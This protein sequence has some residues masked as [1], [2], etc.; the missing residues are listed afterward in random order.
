MT[1]EFC[2]I[3]VDFSAFGLRDLI[4]GVGLL[5][6][7]IFVADEPVSV[8]IILKGFLYL[9]FVVQAMETAA[10]QNV[11]NDHANSGNHEDDV[12]DP[13]DQK[14]EANAV[15]LTAGLGSFLDLLELFFGTSYFPSLDAILHAV[16]VSMEDVKDDSQ[17]Y[18]YQNLQ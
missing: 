7:D 10:E 15:K 13:K 6:L 5:P 9:L 18:L 17:N 14:E 12:L 4:S 3:S 16:E 2:K 11:H 8:F 1:S